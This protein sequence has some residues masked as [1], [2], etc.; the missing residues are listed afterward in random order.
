MAINGT[1]GLV[2]WTPADT[3]VGSQNVS[4]RAQ[5]PGGLSAVQNFSI[6][7][8]PRMIP[9]P[10]VVGSAEAAAK[11]AIITAGLAVGTVT[12]A[13][14]ATVPVGNV[15]SQNPAAGISAAAGSAV[16][17]VVSLGSAMV[18]VP[19]VVGSDE[20]AAKTAITTAGLAVGTVT[21][22]NSATVPTGNVISQNP[23]AATSVAT[24]SAVNLVVSLGPAMVSVP[25]VVGSA[26]E[27]AKTTITT[28]GLTVGTITTA[29]S[30]TVPAG[31]VIS[32]NPA[33]ATSVATGS[34]VNLVVSLGPAMVSVPN[35]VGL[36]EAAAKTVITTAGL[37]VGIV[38]TAN[39]ATVP[40]GNVISQNPATGTSVVADSA[41]ALVISLGSPSVVDIT[42]PK[43]KVSVVPSIV[44]LG[45]PVLITVQAVDDQGVT[46]IR[47]SVNGQNITVD[48]NGQ[49]YFTPAVAGLY[50]VLAE[51]E[52]AAKNIGTGSNTF[53]AHSATDN[54]M[55]TVALTAPA[56]D[57]ILKTV[58]SLTGTA[59]DTDLTLYEL[60][61]AR[62]GSGNYVTFVKGYASVVSGPLGKL[63]PAR[64]SSGVYDV[65]VCALDSWGNHACSSALRYDLSSNL[66]IAGSTNISFFDGYVELGGMPIAIRRI[67]DSRIKTQGD[68]GVGWR[69]DMDEVK[70]E[71]NC[72]MGVNWAISKS[73]GFFPTFT[74]NASREHRIT[75]SLPDGSFHRFRM[76]PDPQ[77]QAIYPI[78]YLNGVIFDPLQGTTSTLKPSSEPSFVMPVLNSSGPVEFYD[79]NLE[80]YDP[81]G[82]TLQLADGR[83]FLF[84]RSGNSLSYKLWQIRDQSGNTITINANGISHSSGASVSY[85]RDANGRIVSLTDPDGH[86]RTYS[87]DAAGDLVATS[88]YEGNITQ[89]RYDDYHNLI[90]VVDARGDIPGTLIY[91]EQGRVAGMIDSK[92]EHVT[93]SRDDT[94]NQEIITDRLGNTTVN[95][96]DAQGNLISQVDALGQ[97]TNFSYD[98][99]G[100]LTSRTDPL[101]NTESFVY[102]SNGKLLKYSDALGNSYTQVFDASGKLT[103]QTDPLGR[104][105]RY[106]YDAAGHLSA[107]VTP[108]GGRV[109]EQYDASGNMIG[110]QSPTGES[111]TFSR[112]TSG[113]INGYSFP[114]G[115]PGRITTRYDGQITSEEFNYGGQLV[116]YDYVYD[117]N[118]NLTD[119]TLPNKATSSLTHDSTGL[120]DTATS[121]MGYTTRLTYDKNGNVMSHEDYNGTKILLE[122]DAENRV[123]TVTAD[124]GQ[125]IERQLDPLGRPVLVRLPGKIEVTTKRDAAGR[126]TN[127]TRTGSGEMKYEYDAV[128]QITK[129]TSAD[130]G[131]TLYEYDKAGQMIRMTDPLGK[132]TT[133]EYDLDGNL[134][135]TAFPDG[136]DVRADYDQSRR[137]KSTRDERGAM[138][139]YAFDNAGDLSS[140]TDTAG[141]ITSYAHD[142]M[143][144]LSQATTSLGKVWRFSYDLLGNETARTFPW[145]GTEH[146][147]LDT[148]GNITQ[149][150]LGDGSATTFEYDA[151]GN[152][153][154]RVLAG[155]HTETLAYNTSG[156]LSSATTS[157]EVVTYNYTGD[158]K[159]ADV[160][161]ANGD[162]IRYGYDRAGR[163]ASIQTQ[164]GITS[165]AYDEMGRLTKMSDT[166]LGDA[167][168]HYDLAGRLADASLPDG[169]TTIYTRNARGFITRILTTT[170]GGNVLRDESIARDA[171]GNPTQIAGNTRVVDYTF[172]TAG[173][174]TGELRTGDD[175][176]NIVY[177]YDGDWNLVR[178][179]GHILNYDESGRLASD[180]LFFNYIYD[181][182]GRPISRSNAMETEKFVYDSLG[183]LI[184]VNRIGASPA[185]VKFEYN[186]KGLLSRIEAD[187]VGRKLLWDTTAAMPVLLE[188][189]NDSG[190]LI[191]R[192]VYGLGPVGVVSGDISIIH[193][194]ILGSTRLMTSKD[195]NL[196]DQYA[197]AAYGDQ[198]LGANS[199]RSMLRFAG[200]Y[201]VP[202]VGFYFLRSRFYDP[203]AGRFLTPDIQAP[204]PEEPQTFNPYLYAG[205]NPVRFSDPLGTFSM[206]E[207]SVA[208]SIASILAGIALPHFPQPVLMLAQTLGLTKADSQVGLSIALSVGK[209][210]LAGGLQLDFLYGPTAKMGVLWIFAGGELGSVRSDPRL[211]GVQ[212]IF[213]AGPIYGAANS[214]PSD[215]RPGAYVM[216]SGTLAHVLGDF[217]FK[218]RDA[219]S[220]IQTTWSRGSAALQFEIVGVNKDATFDSSFFQ[221]FTFYGADWNNVTGDLQ[222]IKE[223]AKD[224]FR[225]PGGKL[226]GRRVWNAGIALSVYLPILWGIWDSNGWHLKNYVGEYF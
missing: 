147:V 178:K 97:Q 170:G 62:A 149:I 153:T 92:G 58:T 99:N 154:R 158:D 82:Y 140:S 51:A 85:T 162:Q 23:A 219:N 63:D 25:N 225:F 143:G 141:G 125:R 205:A 146:Y 175:A 164:S 89:Y 50:N 185:L 73:G 48:S 211:G 132:A 72:G 166:Q 56:N 90:Q 121:P 102:D 18:S 207:V 3:Q 8:A 194:D 223:A 67:Y 24:G 215:P 129:S 84:S 115:R 135:R 152:L 74:L 160:R 176:D 98:A 180:G 145:G 43:V 198:T 126:V 69:L 119:L 131:T 95:N 77:S 78:E 212:I 53:S 52:D 118:G 157:K 57:S 117:G 87:Y 83:Q 64:F 45:E 34:A 133:F 209:G 94:K 213:W 184:Q 173:R 163:L 188:E 191:R 38:T 54:G 218:G 91:D 128:G 161:Y 79:D 41:V 60:Q 202:E 29:N 20:A 104:T 179:G 96:Y 224:V 226:T 108:K 11:T 65:R 123:T 100:N 186:H 159:V 177:S 28:T 59:S 110:Y 127:Q 21:T 101:G 105:F 187:G 171:A 106:E 204:V 221:A 19:N 172:D 210:V 196:I 4:V 5:D 155:G 1:T 32:Q 150:T 112:E 109:Q 35:V 136:S 26:E 217:A 47:L 31:N 182:A 168:Y 15:I 61:A 2:T 68:F 203:S 148:A 103:S 111:A 22:A 206:G 75:V 151:K 193:Q 81:S 174:V 46:V 80:V 10:N 33:A 214:D 12:T 200:E 6:T 156:L 124:G 44:N 39:S 137:L 30:S 27:A 142:E 13:N 181:A 93:I 113:R 167:T 189:R 107:L 222:K 37:T 169:T 130:G 165:Y 197:Y 9:V 88:D 14:S 116:R 139:S 120:P 183:R 216:F 76:R 134:I 114:G 192:Y 7:V 49:A 17:I 40:A 16:S 195:G 138:L 199:D 71:A 36:A 70:L 66:P 86:N 122:R 220:K 208:C 144:N 55:P 190:A 42:L 201:F